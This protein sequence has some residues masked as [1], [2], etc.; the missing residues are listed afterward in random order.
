MGRRG[1]LLIQTIAAGIK[2][3]DVADPVISPDAP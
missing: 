1:A 2:R 3:L